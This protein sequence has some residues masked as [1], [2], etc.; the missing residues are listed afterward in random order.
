MSTPYQ[1]RTINVNPRN[2]PVID[3]WYIVRGQRNGLYD[4]CHYHEDNEGSSVFTLSSV[5]YRE[6]EEPIRCG[7][8]YAWIHPREIKK[9]L[10]MTP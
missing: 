8:C 10:L 3:N 2:F 6:I 7:V 5:N 9:L 1:F 4:F